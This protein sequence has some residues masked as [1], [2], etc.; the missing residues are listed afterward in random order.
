VSIEEHDIPPVGEEIHLPGPSLLPLLSALAIT[1]M[2]IGTTIS[3][4]VSIAG[5]ILFLVT[6]VRWIRDTSHDIDELPEDHR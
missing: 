6:T 3:W 5:L 2:V 4:Y 1:A